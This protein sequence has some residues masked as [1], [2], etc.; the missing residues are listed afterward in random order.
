[1]SEKFTVEIITPEKSILR[2]EAEEVTI[3]SYEG[4]M[5]ILKDHIP[6]IT[7]L[8]PGYINIKDRD[9]KKYFVEEGTVEFAEN[10]LLILTSTVIDLKNFDKVHIKN[11]IQETEKKLQDSSSTDKE[12]YILS[13][14]I[15]TLNEINQ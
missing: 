15:N 10:N 9:E 7:F 5:G 4:Q 11:L 13:Y 1:M 2:S 8:R 3:P 14:K 12:K 6:L